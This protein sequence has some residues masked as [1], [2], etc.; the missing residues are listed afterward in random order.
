MKLPLLYRK[1]AHTLSIPSFSGG[2]NLRDADGRVGDHQLTDGKNM[3]FEGRLLQ[4]R[5]ALKVRDD[6]TGEQNFFPALANDPSV[7]ARKEA[8]TYSGNGELFQLFSYRVSYSVD[9][10]GQTEYKARILF[11]FLSESAQFDLPMLNMDGEN[12]HYFIIQHQNKI[13]C[14]VD[15][16][17]L[18]H[19][20]FRFELTEQMQP[21]TESYAWHE[22]AAE[23]IYAPIVATHG[24]CDMNGGVEAVGAEGM[25]LLTNRYRLVYST[26]NRSLLSA[27][28]PTHPMK[29]FLIHSH[30]AGDDTVV[31]TIT[32]VIRYKNGST[33]CHVAEK[34]AGDMTYRETDLN[35]QTHYGADGLTL[36]SDGFELQFLTPQNG[37]QV[38]AQ[39]GENDYLEDNMT[40]TIDIHNYAETEKML[41]DRERIFGAKYSAWYGGSAFGLSGGGWLFLGGFEGENQNQI[42]YSAVGNP[43]YFSKNSYIGVGQSSQAVT[44]FGKQD[45]SLIIFKERELFRLTYNGLNHLSGEDLIEQA[46]VDITANEIQLSL[47][48]IHGYIGCDAP[49]S[50]ELCR[51]RLVWL[52]GGTVYTLTS[53]SPYSERT[54]LALSGMMDKRLKTE[55]TIA[56]K[57]A[58]SADWNGRYFLFIGTRIYVMDY[59]SAGYL[60]ITSYSKEEDGKRQIPWFYWELNNP[61]RGQSGL[62]LN[63][64]SG[65]PLAAIVDKSRLHLFYVHQAHFGFSDAFFASVCYFDGGMG[66]DETVT[67]NQESLENI[68]ISGKAFRPIDSCF[69]TKTYDFGMPQFRKNVLLVN[70]KI[71]FWSERPADIAFLTEQ[72]AFTDTCQIR[73]DLQQNNRFDG[74]LLRNYMLH[75]AVRAS[76][77]FGLQVK[78]QSPIT[79]DAISFQFKLL[80]GSR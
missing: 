70:L 24:V 74:S 37:S 43:L 38:I 36:W 28:S 58:F 79:V 44:G 32:A 7:T 61:N 45:N 68:V 67:F 19:R 11:R 69:T 56:L 30:I 75:P 16:N 10:A 51:N 26:V 60:Q 47:Q 80:G 63:D 17:K 23:E 72:T 73:A 59:E 46:L 2:I 15:Q 8:V 31:G 21:D 49:Q 18:W 41:A 78:S 55:S 9:N 39:V 4:T 65:I 27:Q 53:Q 22:L 62:Y 42:F 77:R 25:N 29:Y 14:F 20:I 1:Q 33:V 66:D 48:Q 54:V 64:F 40:L 6:C 71:G 57:K 52:C 34:S 3:W 76:D 13:Y 50:I 35:G 5:P 12:V